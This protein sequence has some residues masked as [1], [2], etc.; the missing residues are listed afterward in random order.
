[1]LTITTASGTVHAAPSDPDETGAVLYN[2]T[3]P[4][5]GM[6][7]VVAT[8]DPSQWHKFGAVRITLGS[9]EGLRHLPTGPLPKIRRRAYQ[10]MVVRILEHAAEAAEGWYWTSGLTDTDDRDAPPQASETLHV[11][12]RA[13]G[14][15]YADRPDL[16]Q[17]FRQ[18]HRR[19]APERL[20]WLHRWI[21]KTVA[22]CERLQR[23]AEQYR[24]EAR[25]CAQLWWA[26]AELY[27][28]RPAPA[29]ACLL[30]NRREHLAHRAAYLPRWG[31]IFDEC[32]AF[33]RGRLDRYREEE[34]GLRARWIWNGRVFVSGTAA[35][36][37]AALEAVRSPASRP[38]AIAPEV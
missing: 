29:L 31:E 3:G 6:V 9:V 25:Q 30:A 7:H 32:A 1:M 28:H 16:P 18:A 36:H 8:H 33:E 24:A 26:L 19:E 13:C 10:G 27:V 15:H 12:M 2:L 17:L 34:E 22:D 21:P 23:Q 11:I 37:G 35:V 14:Q 38:G 5:T 4:V 20:A